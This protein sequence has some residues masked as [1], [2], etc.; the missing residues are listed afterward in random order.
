MKTLRKSGTVS[1]AVIAITAFAAS[2]SA[3][4]ATLLATENTAAPGAGETTKN[5]NIYQVV[6]DGTSCQAT[7]LD[8]RET[9]VLPGLT[10]NFN[11]NALEPDSCRFYYSR[12]DR[13][14]VVGTLENPFYFYSPA[15]AQGGVTTS[16]GTLQ[17]GAAGGAFYE[18]EYYYI[19]QR[20]KQLRKAS[21][22]PDGSIASEQEVC[23]VPSD[24]VLGFGDF[25]FDPAQPGVIYGSATE[26][27][28]GFFP[29]FFKMNSDC[30]GYEVISRNDDFGA[31]ALQIAFGLSDGVLYGHSARTGDFF[32]ISTSDGSQ[33][34]ICSAL[35]KN[36]ATYVSPTGDFGGIDANLLK[37]SDLTE[38]ECTADLQGCTPG[39]W[40]NIRKHG[41]SWYGYSPDMLFDDV[42]GV[43]AG[44]ITLLDALK[45]GGGGEYALGR[46]A[47]AAL[48]DAANPDV[49]YTYYESQVI[50]LVQDAFG[51]GDFEP[52]KDL[53]ADA[54]E[55]MCPL[56]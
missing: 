15:D 11:G 26:I 20:T 43:D 52:T 30:S 29:L 31:G 45:R 36:S 8:S 37:L 28:G 7:L 18:G 24:G 32:T 25:T 54:N 16:S 1:A 47:V 38:G 55:Q 53:L 51:S 5:V 39:Y 22:N 40:K 56:N 23:S 46:H 42:F 41:D 12:F 6:V 10:D 17:R 14:N 19:P 34:K 4:G 3:N 9:S 2:L 48:L 33:T 35:D 49:N 44:G 50:A 27:G 21:F 13:D